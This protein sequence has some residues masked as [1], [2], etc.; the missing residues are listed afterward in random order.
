MNDFDNQQPLP[1]AECVATLIDCSL[2]VSKY[3]KICKRANRGRR[4]VF[5]G[6]RRIRKWKEDNCIP[7]NIITAS[8]TSIHIDLQNVLD[9][10][11]FKLLTPEIKEK[12]NVL[13]AEGAKFELHFKYGMFCPVFS[14]N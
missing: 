7:K 3:R 8:A 2:S 6:Y 5:Y 10:Q 14:V 4:R 9:H 13:H 11:L 1:E 12:M